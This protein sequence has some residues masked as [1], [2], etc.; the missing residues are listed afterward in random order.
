MKQY[1]C[2]SF[3]PKFRLEIPSGENINSI[4]RFA[5]TLDCVSFLFSFRIP[6]LKD[7]QLTIVLRP[8]VPMCCRES[9]TIYLACEP[10]AWAQ[11][12][13]QFSHELCHFSIPEKVCSQLRWLE[14]TICETAS[15]YVLPK[16]TLLW[17]SLNIKY[18]VQG[19]GI[20]WDSF[21]RYASNTSSKVIPFDMK[22]ISELSVLEKNCY[23]REK[24]RY[25]A[26]K[27]LPIFI[28]YPDL[29]SAVPA[30]CRVQAD[31]PLRSSLQQWQTISPPHL[32]PLIAQVSDLFL[33]RL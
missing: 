23:L 30:L 7:K 16:M 27:L 6:Q 11:A 22:D 32:R 19:G 12:A 3:L 26:L 29:W 28:E 20:Y 4:S 8:D 1:K 10:N 14:E 17:K 31:L 13:Y 5:F 24:N 2:L 21:E 33:D 9:N 15:L 18:T 25:I